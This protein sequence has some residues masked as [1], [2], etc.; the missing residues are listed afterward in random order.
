MIDILPAI[1]LIGGK[2]VRLSQGDYERRTE[3]DARP[4]EMVRMYAD[5]GVSRIHV[6]DLDG[7][8]AGM[9]KNLGV[10]EKIASLGLVAIEWGG[11][12]KDDVA[13]RDAFN[14]GTDYAIAGSVA[15]KKPDMMKRWLQL[16]G[17]DKVIL[18]AD[19]RDGKVAV[20]GWLEDS[21]MT[22]ERIIDEYIPCGLTQVICTDIS[23]DGM[24]AGPAVDL[25]VGLR[26]KYPE[27]IFT[28]SGGISSMADIV[29]LDEL[30]LPRVIVGKAI[31]ENR[32][33][34]KEIEHY[35]AKQ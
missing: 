6:V 22:V 19:L 18:G 20:S 17:G 4:D 12:I 25:Y 27:T 8:K 26:E 1:D 7:A 31:Y 16:H 28:V 10:L 21:S 13:L 14:A 32:I 5:A 34:L 30:G 2:C 11:G 35:I 23:K 9:P 33:S 15:V 3:Y 24:L 29:R